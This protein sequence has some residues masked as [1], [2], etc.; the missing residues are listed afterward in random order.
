MAIH[1]YGFGSVTD[2]GN[3]AQNIDLDLA[4][5]FAAEGLRVLAFGT[6]NISGQ[7]NF[8]EATVEQVESELN[9]V[10]ITAVEDLLQDDV[11]RCI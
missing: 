11:K 10:G 6:R 8:E 7:T 3:V 5:Q 2:A 1:L 4:N 9:L